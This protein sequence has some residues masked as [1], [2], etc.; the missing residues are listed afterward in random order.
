M[1]RGAG[2]WH[3]GVHAYVA[4][5]P[6]S[7]ATLFYDSFRCQF[8]H[9]LEE[10]L[11][12]RGLGSDMAMRCL[13]QSSVQMSDFIT[14]IFFSRKVNGDM[15]KMCPHVSLGRTKNEHVWEQLRFLQTALLP[16][17]SK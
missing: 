9:L 8:S 1:E 12:H 17:L 15:D 4:G 10:Q 16:S 13:E 5:S 14:A 3:S 11:P 7:P 2:A 6:V